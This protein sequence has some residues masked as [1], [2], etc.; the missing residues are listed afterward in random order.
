MSNWSIFPERVWYDIED[1]KT[2]G[3]LDEGL[4][5]FKIATIQTDGAKAL[6]GRVSASIKFPFPSR[7][8]SAGLVWRAASWHTFICAFM[9]SSITAVNQYKLHVGALHNG[10]WTKL[11][12]TTQTIPLPEGKCQLALQTFSGRAVAEVSAGDRILSIDTLL[13]D[14]PFGGEA[15][16]VRFYGSA[17]IASDFLIEPL[18]MRPKLSK[19]MAND[20]GKQYAHDV[21]IS[22]SSAD[23]QQ[24]KALTK[25]LSD[26]QISY[27]IDHD[28]I[29]FGDPI[30]RKIELGLE[31]SRYV[32][33]CLSQNIAQTGWCRAE[34]TPLLYREFS[35]ETERRVIPLVLDNSNPAQVT[36]LLLSDRLRANFNNP[37]DVNALVSLLRTKQV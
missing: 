14:L 18:S 19:L 15:G 2:S 28:Q 6:N 10:V 33:V 8:N 17:A 26:N 21:F 11:L 1:G 24:V 5:P 37:D 22:Y 20:A 23:L 36:P 27:W 30:L 31:K 25:I 29:K 9:M 32:L 34:Y 12:G 3:Y 13:P 7:V 35:G 4:G 16:L